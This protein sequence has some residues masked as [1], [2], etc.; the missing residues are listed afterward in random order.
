M[1]RTRGEDFRGVSGY[2]GEREQGT[3]NREQGRGNGEWGVGYQ[4][5]ILVVNITV[6]RCPLP[7]FLRKKTKNYFGFWSERLKYKH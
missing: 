2:L 6:A 1:L 3:G 5:C 7:V 4:L